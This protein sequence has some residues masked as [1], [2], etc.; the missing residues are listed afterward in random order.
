MTPWTN[1]KSHRP[2]KAKVT[3]S[4]PVGVTNAYT[5][6]FTTSVGIEYDDRKD[7]IRCGSSVGRAHG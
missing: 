1:R 5:A 2:F 4:T 3:G 7:Y 6:R